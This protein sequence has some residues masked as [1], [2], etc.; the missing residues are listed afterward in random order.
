MSGVW[1]HKLRNW[2]QR[3]FDTYLEEL[4][5]DFLIVGTPGSGKTILMLRIAHELLRTGRVRRVQVVVPTESL[6]QQ[7]AKVARS[8][9]IILSPSVHNG[10]A[11]EA[12]DQHGCVVT[13]ASVASKPK[14]HQRWVGMQPT[15]GI[16]DEVHHAG[17]G[18]EESWGVGLWEAFQHAPYRVS[19]SGTPWRSTSRMRF[20]RY[21]EC[22]ESVANVTYG[23][24]D[25]IL[26]GVCRPVFFPSVDGMA[27]WTFKGK[28]K[29]ATLQ[30][31]D[32]SERDAA[33]R[34]NTILDAGGNW[35][36][37]VIAM[38]HD[39]LRDIRRRDD[40]AGGLIVCKDQRHAADVAAILKRRHAVNPTVVVSDDP[41]SQ[42]AIQRYI[43]DGSLWIVAV[44][45]VTE[46]VDIKRLR[47]GIYATNIASELFFR[48]V[49][50]RLVRVRD[51]IPAGID[52]TSY[53]YLPAVEEL[54]SYA[55]A[56]RDE[57]VHAMEA[58]ADEGPHADDDDEAGGGS[59]GD[60]GFDPGRSSCG[61]LIG[62]LADKEM[63]SPDDIAI[64]K[65]VAQHIGVAGKLNDEDLAKLARYMQ[66]AGAVIDDPTPETGGPSVDAREA[67]QREQERQELHKGTQAI[68]RKIGMDAKEMVGAEFNGWG[69][70]KIAGTLTKLEAGIPCNEDPGN[71]Q[72]PSVEQ[73]R[74]WKAAADRLRAKAVQ[75]RRTGMAAM[76]QL[77]TES[78]NRIRGF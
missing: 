61:E 53:M 71:A 50:G 41:D 34:L 70:F 13:Y 24:S 31:S 77:L 37:S 66:D 67:E 64:G 58:M 62:V 49:C 27:E 20:V 30:Q 32:I 44:R 29:K 56:M 36:T 40:Q 4:L 42:C 46:G 72:A 65:S 8:V 69:V 12:T 51:D 1:T 63:L 11:R 38:A 48:Q 28:P 68:I 25:A 17:T 55:H 14:V 35:L 39:R 73:L 47:T 21:N 76:E 43:E 19:G 3:A 15:L 45:M 52:Q 2:Q 5:R 57:R 54:L 75:A 16:F 7:W 18:R 78:L 10:G 23:Y 22:N 6:K 26:D 33:Q 60:S 9:G 74:L 59:R